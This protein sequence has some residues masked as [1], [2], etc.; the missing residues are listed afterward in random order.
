MKRL[1]ASV[2]VTTSLAGLSAFGQGYFQFTAPKHTVWDGFTNPSIP[3]NTT[4]VNVAF[5]WAANGWTPQVATILSSTP[6]NANELTGFFTPGTAWTAILTDP[7][8]VLAVDGGNGQVAVAR[9]TSLGALNYNGGAAFPVTGTSAGVT[10][11]LF[12]VGWDARYAT[13]ALAAAVNSVVGWSSP[14]KYPSFVV[15]ATPNFM[16]VQQFGV[17]VNGIPEPTSFALAGLGSL[18]LLLLSRRK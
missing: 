2:L 5:L 16:A 15:T 14:F 11:T 18:A 1:V 3:Q 6:T 17:G 4:N 13:P 7:N 12:M 10:Y 9:S 8:F